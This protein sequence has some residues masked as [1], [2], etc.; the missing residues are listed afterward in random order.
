MNHATED[1]SR[2]E[3]TLVAALVQRPERFLDLRS[4]EPGD[5]LAHECRVVFLVVGNYHRQAAAR[6]F[7]RYATAD[8]IERGL[9]EML[10][11]VPKD[12]E[13][14]LRNA[15]VLSAAL[16]LL[17]SV[18]SWPGVTD[19]EFADAKD[20]MRLQATDLRARDGL[21]RLV[22]RIGQGRV[23]GLHRELSSLA[24]RV[25]PEIS[26]SDTITLSESAPL[27]LARYRTLK[28]TGAGNIETPYPRLNA[29]TGGGRR[30]RMWVLGAFTGDGKT[31][32]MVQLAY[33]AAVTQSVGSAL[34]V[35]EQT[36][37]EIED[38]FIL[39]H[40]H[41]FSPGGISARRYLDGELTPAEEAVLEKT[42][43]DWVAS[44]QGRISISQV[45]A[46]TTID[47]VRSIAES[48]RARHP[49]DIIGIDHS[50]LFSTNRRADNNTGRMA[51]VIMEAKQLAMQ[52]ADKA[53]AWVLLPH[54]I[55]RE[56]NE[57]ALKRGYYVMRDLSATSEAERSADVVLWGLRSPEMRNVSEM[58]LGTCKDRK[59][60]ALD[61]G[62][63]VFERFETGA[64]LP[65]DDSAL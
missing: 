25:N 21:V 1:S 45:P 23:E 27:A 7:L 18:A 55:T 37:E 19:H 63:R 4:I 56:G 3:Q 39:R 49:V 62:F 11:P 22:D 6:G 36:K 42:V 17:D 61:Y 28:E 59:G 2:T 16:A 8:A 50:A 40:A 5:F 48:I 44:G 15:S 52:F 9:R 29:S 13:R 24:A 38:L 35:G 57:A 43:H 54:Q 12:K 53:G 14:T 32:L 26:G 58:T 46:G 51:A 47:E 65:I 34:F 31:T 30:S 64:I 20:Q 33:H 10:R 41:K 60:T